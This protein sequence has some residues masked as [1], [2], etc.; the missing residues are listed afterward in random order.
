LTLS[1]I[2]NIIIITVAAVIRQA[3][4]VTGPIVGEAAPC[5][6]LIWCL[7]AMAWIPPLLAN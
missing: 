7:K 5:Q 2:N 1:L 6:D 3:W 4:S